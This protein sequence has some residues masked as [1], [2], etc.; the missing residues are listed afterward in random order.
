MAERLFVVGDD[1]NY[2][3]RITRVQITGLSE[4]VFAGCSQ[5]APTSTWKTVEDRKTHL[6]FSRK[7]AGPI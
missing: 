3:S 4:L 7:L 5:L 2:L 6:K 1:L